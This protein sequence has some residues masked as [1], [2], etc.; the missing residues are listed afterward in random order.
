MK[1]LNILLGCVFVLFAALQYNDVDPYIW[2]PVYGYAAAVCFMAA[3]GRYHKWMILTGLTVYF[4]YMLRF[5]PG[6]ESW[7][8]QHEHENIAQTMKA[9]KPWIEE[10]REFFGLLILVIVFLIHY[11]RW[12]RQGKG[13][14]APQA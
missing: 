5:T 4:L 1:A 13:R 7:F 3:A 6:L 11:F 9:T 8:F 10:T 12:R 2:V 14:T